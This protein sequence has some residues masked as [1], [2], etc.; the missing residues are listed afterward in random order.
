MADDALAARRFQ[1]AQHALA[2]KHQHIP[3]LFYRGV[4]AVGE[5]ARPVREQ[6]ALR[7]RRVHFAHFLPDLF[8]REGEDGGHHLRHRLQYLP[9]DGADRAAA[10]GVFGVRIKFV[11]AD[12]DVERRKL[13]VAELVD[14][15]HRLM[16]FVFVESRRHARPQALE[17]QHDVLVDRGELLMRQDVRRGIKTVEVRE[18]EARRVAYPS[19]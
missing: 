10:H 17:L 6:D 5:A 19:V 12:V 7:Q 2:R 4:D 15:R 9:H 14:E 11:L 1:A 8:R 3:L 13:V 16:E 18:Q